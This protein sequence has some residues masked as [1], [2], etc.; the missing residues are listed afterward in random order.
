MAAESDLTPATVERELTSRLSADGW[1]VTVSMEHPPRIGM[2]FAHDLTAT[3]FYSGDTSKP[4]FWNSVDAFLSKPEFDRIRERPTDAPHAALI[5]S[6]RENARGAR[7]PNETLD[8]IAN[9]LEGH[10]VLTAAE[11]SWLRAAG[12][13]WDD[14]TRLP[15]PTA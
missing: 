8:V 15:E 3:F 6:L 9:V 12:P 11:A 2:T 13:A 7:W 5:R 4:G 14:G 10:D 1:T